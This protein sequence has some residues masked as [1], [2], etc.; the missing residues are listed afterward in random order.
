LSKKECAKIETSE[1]TADIDFEILNVML[2]CLKV[3]LLSLFRE[4]VV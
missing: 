3:D 1:L 4:F 2:V